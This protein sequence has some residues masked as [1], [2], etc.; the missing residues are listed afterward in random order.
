[1]R[2]NDEELTAILKVA[3]AMVMADGR[4]DD[5]EKLAI[6]VE[7][8]R[9]GVP[10]ERFRK[11]LFAIGT[12]ENVEA[13]AIL[14]SLDVEKKKHVSSF[15]VAIMMS[16]GDID[17]KEMALWKLVSTICDF[18]VMSVIEAADMWMKQNK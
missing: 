4:I 9:L 15:L 6:G 12:I 18:P 16:D 3:M 10:N 5:S 1:M 7:M 2:F 13:F 14:L 11:L 8:A 17:E